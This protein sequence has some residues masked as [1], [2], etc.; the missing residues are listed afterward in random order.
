MYV[1]ASKVYDDCIKY[2]QLSLLEQNMAK[3]HES[4]VKYRSGGIAT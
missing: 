2:I 4:G 1:T 3:L